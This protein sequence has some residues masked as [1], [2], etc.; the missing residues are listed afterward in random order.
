MI[1]Q[2]QKLVN[3]QGAGYVAKTIIRLTSHTTS[4]AGKHKVSQGEVR[5]EH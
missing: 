1:R 2:G 5:N 4:S 3:G